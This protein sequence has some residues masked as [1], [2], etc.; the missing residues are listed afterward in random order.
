M[1]VTFGHCTSLNSE[2]TEKEELVKTTRD[3]IIKTKIMKTKNKKLLAICILGIL[4]FINIHA[5]SDNKKMVNSEVNTIKTEILN[6]ETIKVEDLFLQSAEQI[7]ALEADAQIEK[8]ANQQVL[9]SE[10]SKVDTD[11][12]NA[13]EISTANEAE[14]VVAKF[15]EKQISLAKSKNIK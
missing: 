6:S 3:E 14:S 12:L 15:A 7:T 10:N 13:A 9:L 1:K 5:I 4:G 11:F 2:T 8:Y